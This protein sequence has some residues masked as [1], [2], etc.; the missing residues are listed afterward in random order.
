MREGMELNK[1]HC[2][3]HSIASILSA[4]GNIT[5]TVQSGIEELTK[6][7]CCVTTFFSLDTRYSIVEFHEYRN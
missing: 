3:S 7:S 1:S 4:D 6:S 2:G 5:A